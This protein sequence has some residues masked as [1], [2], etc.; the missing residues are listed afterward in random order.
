MRVFASSTILHIYK[1]TPS[2]IAASPQP[3]ASPPKNPTIDF[4]PRNQ[5]QHI[6]HLIHPQIHNTTSNPT[7]APSRKPYQTKPAKLIS[8]PSPPHT[9]PKARKDAEPGVNS[10]TTIL[11]SHISTYNQLYTTIIHVQLECHSHYGAKIRHGS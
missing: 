1:Q 8:L 4:H 11:R 9:A 7:K 2:E 6:S 3:H 10:I 5:N